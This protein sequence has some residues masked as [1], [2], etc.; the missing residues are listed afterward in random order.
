VMFFV[1]A[2][3]HLFRVLFPTPSRLN[4]IGRN[5]DALVLM[6]FQ[7]GELG[8]IGCVHLWFHKVWTVRWRFP[9]LPLNL[10]FFGWL[11]A[12]F[13]F[14][15]YDLENVRYNLQSLLFSIIR[16]FITQLW[17]PKLA[18]PLYFIPT[19]TSPPL[20]AP[21][22]TDQVFDDF[23]F[24]GTLLVSW[25]FF[26]GV[27]I[28]L[29]CLNKPKVLAS[30]HR[31]IPHELDESPDDMSHDQAELIAPR[32]G[33]RRI[34][35]TG[36]PGQSRCQ[37]NSEFR[38]PLF[39]VF[40]VL[41]V[42]HL[43][44]LGLFLFYPMQ[45]RLK[46]FSIRPVSF[47]LMVCMTHYERWMS[48]PK[49]A[50]ASQTARSFLPPGRYWLDGRERPLFPAMH[51][52]FAA[53]CAYNRDNETCRTFRKT[54]SPTP[55][56]KPP[57]VVLLIY[58]SMNP[59]TYLI[60]GEFL[61]E[62]AVSTIRDPNFLVSETPFY[63][64]TLMPSLRAFARDGITFAGLSS[65]GLPTFSG[66]HGLMTGA[67]PS[68]T[69][70]NMVDGIRAQTD[71]IPTFMRSEGY[72]SFYVSAVPLAY[73]GVGN[74]AFRRPAIEEALIQM[75]CA[76]GY[77][78]LLGD[79]IQDALMPRPSM[80]NCSRK[81]REVKRKAREFADRDFPKWFDYVACYYPN[82]EQGRLLN[83]S[84]ETLSNRDWTPDRITTRQFRLHWRQQRA[85]LDR[86]NQTDKPI[87]AGYLDSES[88]IPYCGYDLEQF[89]TPLDPSLSFLSDD[90]RRER[91][92]RV[93]H[94][95]DEY[96][97]NETIDF[98]RKEDPHTIVI[99][100]GDHGTRDVPIRRKNSH[101]TN[102]TVFS[103]D[104]VDGSSGV[105]SFFAVSGII[106]YLGDDPTV[107]AALQLDRL[108]GKTLKMAC[109][110]NDL[111]Y[112][113]ID[114]VSQF[115]GHSIPPSSRRSRNL[116]NLSVQM[117]DDIAKKGNQAALE[118]I[119]RSNWQS[120]SMVSG[121]LEFRNGSRMLR[122][123]PMDPEGAHYYPG[124][125]FPTCLKSEDAP[126]METGGEKVPEMSE[127]MFDWL[128][129][130]NFMFSMN[131]LFHYKFRDKECVEKGNC[132]FPTNTRL[133]FNNRFFYGGVIFFPVT[134]G[135]I[136]FW[137][138]ALCYVHECRFQR[139]KRRYSKAVAL[140]EE[141]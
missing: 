25:I 48:K 27:G 117:M 67:V 137:I 134:G 109:D 5:S 22:V 56:A 71:D 108:R 123:H 88:H 16:T 37:P 46:W 51:G 101:V 43:L 126:E 40:H 138:V 129:S 77:G 72:R 8:Y 104:C 12:D 132:A 114:L 42:F 127:A 116:I 21:F 54:P 45:H 24:F 53:F 28:V 57:N 128:E 41:M 31:P 94:Y 32:G 20:I 80:L 100:T 122:I 83:L 107:K 49:Q 9:S 60:D 4:P 102:R 34:T 36:W 35:G 50:R 52:D 87:F 62:Q 130:E 112:T 78:D 119:D 66:M 70:M 124:V 113:V 135:L 38:R 133:K 140:T 55:M 97:I 75:R 29:L 30:V 120:L 65:L 58:E 121:Q 131:R 136:G 125:S 3:L 81:Q 95:V 115:N 13:L 18:I 23:T 85:F 6:L 91:F 14:A 33:C 76:E 96:F 89:Y 17:L 26:A 86:N 10:A 2:I 63:D 110:H 141:F 44:A 68:Q 69:F 92:K 79:P 11:V 19:T 47:N 39:V 90:H 82:E 99:L 139:K 74:W 84:S 59:S 111:M 1:F 106:N 98:L 93:N 61:D 118:R 7:T 15:F 105:D 64:R 73:D 103:G